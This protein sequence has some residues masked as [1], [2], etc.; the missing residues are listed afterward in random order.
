MLRL[1]VV[2]NCLNILK[3]LRKY[4]QTYVATRHSSIGQTLST[5]FEAS[6]RLTRLSFSKSWMTGR[7]E[8]LYVTI[9]RVGNKRTE[10]AR[11]RFGNVLLPFF[12]ACFV[13]IGA[14]TSFAAL[15]AS[16]NASLNND[17]VRQTAAKG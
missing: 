12:Q 7:V 8:S 10:G 2:E 9:L 17:P 11:I 5:S 3:N 1:E 4:G 15:K 14:S 6:I 13:I 16:T